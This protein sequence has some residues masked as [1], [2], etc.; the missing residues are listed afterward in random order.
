MK[1]YLVPFEHLAS[2]R[3]EDAYRND[4]VPLF[5]CSECAALVGPAGR[6]K[7]AD[8]HKTMEADRG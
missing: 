4:P 8:W 5:E 3:D 6:Q 7:H 2:V 1:P